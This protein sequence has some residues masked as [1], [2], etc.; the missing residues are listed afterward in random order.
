MHSL[1]LRETGFFK[2]MI[3][4]NI[5]KFFCVCVRAGACVTLPLYSAQAGL[6]LQI[7]LSETPGTCATMYR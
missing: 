4:A 2:Y 7:M 6:E 3:L 1:V 5:I